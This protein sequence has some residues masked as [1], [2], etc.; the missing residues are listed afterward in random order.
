M[1]FS[2][3]RSRLFSDA[4]RRNMYN[5]R[6]RGWLYGRLPPFLSLAAGIGGS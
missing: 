1:L 6:H 2:V 3:L 4:Q 5:L